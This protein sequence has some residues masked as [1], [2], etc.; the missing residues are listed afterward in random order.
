MRFINIIERIP[1]KKIKNF[2]FIII[3]LIEYWLFIHLIININF[4]SK[5]IF[6]KIVFEILCLILSI[7]YKN[8]YRVILN[9]RFKIKELQ[10]KS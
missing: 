8:R 6:Q 1:E 7:I 10:E 4:F 2:G 5:F 9:S 3:I